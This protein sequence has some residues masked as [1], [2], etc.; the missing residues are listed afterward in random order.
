MKKVHR[1]IS[2]VLIVSVILTA[3][4]GVH[5]LLNQRLLGQL[6]DSEQSTLDLVTSTLRGE[7]RQFEILAGVLAS[8]REILQFFLH[9]DP[10]SKSQINR[11][12][13]DINRTTG[14]L[15]TYLMNA[16]GITIA[17]SNWRKPVSFVGKDFSYRP[18]YQ[19][20]ILGQA[21]NFF[22]IGTSSNLR[23][24]YVSTPVFDNHK[25]VGVV[26]VKIRVDHLER[27]WRSEN[28]E[29]SLV[30]D[31]GV[32][33]VSTNPD[34]RQ[35]S[36]RKLTDEQIR[37]ISATRRY[38][39]A[40][41]IEP[42]DYQLNAH[43]ESG[44]EII[45]LNNP[46][47]GIPREYLSLSSKM[48]E[49][50]WTV[51]LTSRTN[52]VSRI[53]FIGSAA[54]G[55]GFAGIGI[56]G[57][58]I[59]NR[60]QYD[61]KRLESAEKYKNKLEMAIAKRTRDLQMS[62]AELIE[63]QQKLIQSGRL[64]AIGRFSAGLSHEISQPLTA[65]HSYISNAQRLLDLHRYSEADTKLEHIASLADRI[66]LIIQQLKIFVR[67]DELSTAPVSLR[68]AINEARII[69]DEQA[70]KL[71]AT[72]AVNFPDGD[73]H[74]EGDEILL[75]Q[76]FVN[77]LSNA[78][79]AASESG[80]AYIDINVHKKDKLAVIEV[81]DNGE[82]VSDSDL[83][84]IFDPFYSTKDSGRGLGLG[85]TIAQEIANRFRGEMTAHNNSTGGA[86]FTVRAPLFERK[87]S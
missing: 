70:N 7:I 42:L 59:F 69:M 51:L 4:A 12:L 38:P 58:A 65:I 31:S 26:V 43:L 85:L 64:A 45:Q 3:L 19:I 15:D 82:G 28:R 52:Q 36:L 84:N 76:L 29:L 39:D 35:H 20:A 2:I 57:Y 44:E 72:I 34:W 13:E 83:P 37:H 8:N 62:N 41:N 63:T 30:D 9:E 73:L 53:A 55:F 33:F 49:A 60:L 21:G 14:A 77:L 32:L 80:Q 54:I 40:A 66:T 48:E 24:F 16:D 27:L 17:A 18:Y 56:I 75:Q 81:S 61:R 87:V 23:G 22:A 46:T 79:D 78:L 6:R 25:P 10:A 86:T 50:N 71:D 68:N 5:H 11:R 67:G 1:S 74:V 47:T